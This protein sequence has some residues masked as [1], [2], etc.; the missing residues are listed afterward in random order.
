MHRTGLMAKKKFQSLLGIDFASF[1]VTTD[2][3]STGS[4]ACCDMFLETLDWIV[5]PTFL[6]ELH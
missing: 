2:H 4:D 6:V 1:S 5:R 3:G